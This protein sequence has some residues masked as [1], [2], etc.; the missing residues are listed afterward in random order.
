MSQARLLTAPACL[1][2]GW[3]GC[4]KRNS[5]FRNKF[6][7]EYIFSVQLLIQYV[8]VRFAVAA[9]VWNLTAICTKY[10]Q[11][12]IL[13]RICC[14]GCAGC[15][16]VFS[17]SFITGE[18]IMGYVISTFSRSCLITGNFFNERYVL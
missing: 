12:G 16:S 1:L 8:T 17:A 6:F 4:D 15:L 5:R 18:S 11:T 2:N 14:F 10:T 7:V 13:L 9:A 3:G